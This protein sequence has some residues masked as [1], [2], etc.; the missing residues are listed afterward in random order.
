MVRPFSYP[1]ILPSV[2]VF[3]PQVQPVSGP[4]FMVSMFSTGLY[5]MGGD[6]VTVIEEIR[7]LLDI[8]RDRK[9]PREDYLGE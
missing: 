3:S 7:N 6:P 4:T 9:N 1:A 2:P 5:N 8:G